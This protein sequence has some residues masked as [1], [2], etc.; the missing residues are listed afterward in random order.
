MRA[1]PDGY[2]LLLVGAPNTINAAA[3]DEGSRQRVRT[4]EDPEVYLLEKTSGLICS[5]SYS[6][7]LRLY[8]KS[9]SVASLL[10]I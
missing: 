6:E 9:F 3:F 1:A 2:T 8:L 10:R 4:V 5:G 7:R